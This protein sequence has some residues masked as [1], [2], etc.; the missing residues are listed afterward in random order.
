[1][2][3]TSKI[4]IWL[5]GI[6]SGLFISLLIFFYVLNPMKSE[7]AGLYFGFLTLPWSILLLV[8]TLVLDSTGHP[9]AMPFWANLILLIIFAAINSRCLY[10]LGTEINKRGKESYNN[11]I[12]T[13]RE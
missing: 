2:N 3:E 12:E 1:M 7:F 11:A 6:Y 10:K 13:D 5:S 4:G 9:D 8:I